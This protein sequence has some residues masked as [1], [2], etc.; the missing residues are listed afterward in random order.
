MRPEIVE[1]TQYR[2][3]EPSEPPT[4]MNRYFC[5]APLPALQLTASTSGFE[6]NKRLP[7]RNNLGLNQGRTHCFSLFGFVR[8]RLPFIA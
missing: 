8:L 2:A 7:S 5:N 4:A 1:P 3:M 6:E